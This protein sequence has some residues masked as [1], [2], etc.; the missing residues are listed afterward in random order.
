MLYVLS[1]VGLFAAPWT[2]G[3]QTPLPMGFS[4]QESWSVVSFLNPEDVPDP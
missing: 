3:H 4:R 2:V 1:H